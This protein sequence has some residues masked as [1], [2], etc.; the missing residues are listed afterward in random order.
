MAIKINGDTVIDNS[1]NFTGNSLNT[2][3]NFGDS[4]SGG[5]TTRAESTAQGQLSGILFY[6]TFQNTGDNTARRTADIWAGFS[7]SPWGAEYLAFGAGQNGAANDGG[8]IT[9]ERMRINS[10]GLKITTS[11]G[12]GANA[13][14][15]TGEIRATNNITAYYSDERLKDFHGTIPNALDKISKLNG[16][17]FTENQTAKDLGYS[18]DRMQ[19]G[20][21]AQEVER[22]FPE[23]VTNSAIENDQGYKTIW[24]DKM[25]PLLVEAIKEQQK[26]IDNQNSRLANL[27]EQLTQ[28]LNKTII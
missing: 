2:T 25:V 1:K 22:V 23:I 14:G 18:N 11:L 26:I 16:Y 3:K 20:L 8:N 15:T 24:Y 12:V 5:I 19:V 17:Y 7:G 13:S 10:S 4:H 21:S 6:S 27:E 9:F 28:L